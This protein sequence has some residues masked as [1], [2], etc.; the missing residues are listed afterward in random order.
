MSDTVRLSCLKAMQAALAAVQAGQ[1]GY[2]LAFNQ[3]VLGPIDA[4]EGGRRR[5][6]VGIVPGR[7]VTDIQFPLTYGM[8]P[9]AIEF[10]VTWNMG[11]MPSHELAEAVL[12]DIRR[13]M[14]QD[15]SL[16]GLAIDLKDM[17]NE[18]TLNTFADKNIV[19]VAH[20]DLLYRHSTLDPRQPV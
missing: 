8:L 4:S 7:E 11:D 12:G 20:F 5:A 1:D 15:P 13:K 10:R 9:I 18:I 16:G 6:M 19:G 14:M 2:L 17:G 3:V